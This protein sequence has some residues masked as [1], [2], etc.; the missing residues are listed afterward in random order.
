MITIHSRIPCLKY[1]PKIL[2]QSS[3][4]CCVVLQRSPHTTRYKCRQLTSEIEEYADRGPRVVVLTPP[5]ECISCYNSNGSLVVQSSVDFDV[6][7]LAK[8]VTKRS[9]DTAIRTLELLLPLISSGASVAYV[10]KEPTFR[11]L[12]F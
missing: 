8:L 11:K 6:A 10:R 5:N 2:S 4:V 12:G 1:S 7:Q 9:D 3:S